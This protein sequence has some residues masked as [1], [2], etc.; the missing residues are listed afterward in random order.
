MRAAAAARGPWL[1]SM[2]VRLPLPALLAGSRPCSRADTCDHTTRHTPR[3][4]HHTPRH[5]PHT[6][7]NRPQ[8][9]C[10]NRPFLGS[11]WSYIATDGAMR[12]LAE[13]AGC[14]T[15][16]NCRM[17]HTTT[18]NPKPPCCIK[19]LMQPHACAPLNVQPLH[20]PP[21]AL[22]PRLQHGQPPPPMATTP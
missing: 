15:G 1:T 16:G 11:M 22:Q 17:G 3:V 7:H 13:G 19:L 6:T 10:E 21:V 14:S 4:M 18:L 20:H 2:P 5:R 9:A 12:A 8:R